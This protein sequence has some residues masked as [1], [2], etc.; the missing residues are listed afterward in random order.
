MAK[1]FISYRRSDSKAATRRIHAA[2]ERAFGKGSTF[3]DADIGVGD[4]LR[5]VMDALGASDVCVVVIGP[6]W[7]TVTDADTGE[8]RLFQLDDIVR[9]EVE[10]GLLRPLLVTILLDGTPMPTLAQ[11][12]RS[13]RRLID[14]Q[15]FSVRTDAA[16]FEADIARVIGAIKGQIR[17]PLRRWLPIAVGVAV[18]AAAAFG[19][20]TLLNPGGGLTPTP[21]ATDVALLPTDTPAPPLDTPTVPVVLP[22]PTDTPPPAPTN[23][24]LRASDELATLIAADTQA[25][26]TAIVRRPTETAQALFRA[27]TETA[28]AIINAAETSARATLLARSFTPTFTPSHT[29]T[30][31]RTFTPTHTPTAT[32]DP[33]LALALRF[34]GTLNDDW[35]PVTREFDG[36]PMALV[37]VGC[38][39]MGSDTY[40]VEQPVHDQCITE[41]FWIDV[42]EVTQADF[43]RQGG[44]KANANGF[45]GDAK[46]VEQITWVE[47]RDFCA[48]RGMRLPTEAEWE[49]AARGVE[50]LSYPWGNTFVEAN[51]VFSGNSGN[52][53]A[54]VGSRPGGASWVGALDL[55]GNVWEWVLS[56][57]RGYPY[58]PDDGR[59]NISSNENRV[60]RGGS[61]GNASDD[62]RAANRYD[63]NPTNADVS[64]GFRC[65]LSARTQ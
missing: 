10:L 51:A 59:E 63:R 16:D 57:Y 42:T 50:S 49:F 9:R 36:V 26:Q 65:A 28:Q 35:T 41:P 4:W 20:V 18:V 11:L 21:T 55:S 38:F 24:T 12:P 48:R 2:F 31:S 23:G 54:A 22:Q 40:S 6:D 8:K 39:R 44:V 1:I 47:A 17:G 60:V 43:E 19:L 52:Q 13:L 14:N 37:P 29:L 30:P 3:I 32:T 27:Q 64:I 58:T 46:P 45:D 61:F 15:A 62:L 7:L 56:E 25:T 5:Q 34:A 53:T 33:L